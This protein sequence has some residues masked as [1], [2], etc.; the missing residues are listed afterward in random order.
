[1]QPGCIQHFDIEYLLY[2]LT[3]DYIYLAAYQDDGVLGI[4][5]TRACSGIAAFLY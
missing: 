1:M 2:K 3:T 4:S 5:P